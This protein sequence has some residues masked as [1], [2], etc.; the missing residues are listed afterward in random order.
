MACNW[1]RISA[2]SSHDH[3]IECLAYKQARTNFGSYRLVCGVLCMMTLPIF[4]YICR[5][6]TQFEDRKLPEW[7]EPDRM[8]LSRFVPR[9]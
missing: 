8:L 4:I 7:H 6:T 1:E 3:H 5:K 2:S 9:D